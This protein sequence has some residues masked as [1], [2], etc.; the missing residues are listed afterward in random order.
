MGKSTRGLKK[1][2]D[3]YE[4]CVER[5][6]R[7][8]TPSKCSK[9]CQKS[10]VID[11]PQKSEEDR[12]GIFSKFWENLN[13]EQRK[14]YVNSL[15]KKEETKRPQAG[16]SRR[17]Y[18]YRYTLWKNDEKIPVCKNMF[19]STLGIDEYTFY[20]WLKDASIGIP[21]PSP[22]TKRQEA[23]MKSDKAKVDSVNRS[24]DQIPKMESYYCRSSSS[25]LYIQQ[26][27]LTHTAL[28]KEYK[29]YCIQHGYQAGEW[30]LF[31]KIFKQKNLSLFSPRKDQCDVCF[32]HT[33]GNISDEVYLDHIS[34]KN[35]AQLEKDLDKERGNVDKTVIVITLDLEGVMLCPKLQASALYNK[36]KLACHN[37]TVFDL[38]QKMRC[39]IFGMWGRATF[40]VIHLPLVSRNILGQF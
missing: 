20:A 28:F 36:T 16:A 19:L 12:Q 6:E 30:D 13:W 3:R 34:K 11:C 40:P 25:K 32:A 22:K 8:L 17:G 2:D 5:G 29:V 24:L 15:V 18:S 39:A 37:F 38:K 33:E 23:R 14:V 10:K 7:I 21:K 26:M 4:F 9:R 1:V 27:Y 35:A 31:I